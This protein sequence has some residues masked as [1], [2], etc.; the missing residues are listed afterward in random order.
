MF[1]GLALF[2]NAVNSVLEYSRAGILHWE[3]WRLLSAHMAHTNFIH[4]VMNAAAWVLIMGIVGGQLSWQR[5]SLSV[6]VMGLGI[7]LL[8]FWW[9]PE[10]NAYVGFSGVLH[11][12]LSLG[13]MH[14]VVVL[15]D[16]LHAAALILL[17]VKIIREQWPGFNIQH[18]D[19]LIDASV[20]V[21]AHLY[22][23]ILGVVMFC[24]FYACDYLKSR[25]RNS[26]ASKVSE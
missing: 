24:V 2:H 22:G 17:V 5:W 12:L 6:F 8:L 26:K 16:K 1:C 19:H 18:L 11:G 21:D 20:V 14:S 25:E 23:A 3:L 15:K 7:S 9:N 10:I 13:L 4:G